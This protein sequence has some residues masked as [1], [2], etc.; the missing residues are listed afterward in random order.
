M[1]KK[2]KRR[3]SLPGVGPEAPGTPGGFCLGGYLISKFRR[4]VWAYHLES[5][6]E[7]VVSIVGRSMMDCAVGDGSLGGRIQKT[8]LSSGLAQPGSSYKE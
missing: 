3:A 5:S 7:A 1:A 8:A 6:A 2:R 4:E